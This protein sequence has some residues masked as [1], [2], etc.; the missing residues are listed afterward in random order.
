[1]R[2]TTGA[3]LF[4][5]AFALAW[6]LAGCRGQTGQPAATPPSGA[7]P[8]VAGAA[9]G[10]EQ[11]AGPFQVTLSTAAT[12]KVGETSFQVKV[13]RDGQP[14][15]GATVAMS[16]SMPSMQMAGPEVTLQPAGSRYEGTANL[17]M[18]GEWEAKTT[19]TA[20]GET[21]AAAYRFTAA[22]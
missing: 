6:G 11:A 17:T 20:G 8:A 10:T 22:K 18:A 1:M 2:R 16:L 15:N 7:P 5:G 3:L 14:V 13:A 21:G 19:V 9:L 4:I 12:P